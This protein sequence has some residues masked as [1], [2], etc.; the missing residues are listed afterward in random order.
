[1]EIKEDA[2]EALVN[3]RS[4][5]KAGTNGDIPVKCEYPVDLYYD[6]NTGKFYALAKVGNKKV[7]LEEVE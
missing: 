2:M 1:M 5:K 6:I 3:I 7:T 4:N